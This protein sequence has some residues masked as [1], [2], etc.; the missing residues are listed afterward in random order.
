M[1]TD[2][3]RT[4]KKVYI[5]K[6]RAFIFVFVLRRVRSVVSLPSF[7]LS[8]YD[9]HHPFGEGGRA[10]RGGFDASARVNILE[11]H[12]AEGPHHP[13]Q[14]S[15]VVKGFLSNSAFTSASK[16]QVPASEFK[17]PTVRLE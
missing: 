15:G 3:S 13:R 16:D 14:S 6:L 12:E 10:Q 17:P 4:R 2:T 7:Q 11:W 1:L 5:L 8:G 9:Q